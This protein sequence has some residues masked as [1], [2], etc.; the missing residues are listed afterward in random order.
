MKVIIVKQDGLV[1]RI[2]EFKE[3]WHRNSCDSLSLSIVPDDRT[4]RS[5]TAISGDF[6]LLQLFA[7]I[8]LRNRALSRDREDF[9][10]RCQKVFRKN[11]ENNKNENQLKKMDEQLRKFKEDIDAD[12]AVLR[13]YT[14]DSFL[15]RI[16]NETLR[17]DDVVILFHSRYV[18]R[19]LNEQLIKRQ[20][21]SPVR[22]YRGQRMSTVE[23]E[24]LGKSKGKLV[25]MKSFLSTSL[26]RRI[27]EIYADVETH[28]NTEETACVIFII[29]AIPSENN[30]KLRPFAD[31][32][33]SSHFGASESEI[34]FM[35][36]SV[37]QITNVEQDVNR[38][39]VISMTTCDQGDIVLDTL[40]SWIGDRQNINETDGE[41]CHRFGE[42]LLGIGMPYETENFYHHLLKEHNLFPPNDNELARC[43]HMLGKAVLATELAES[44]N[45]WWEK[46]SNRQP[47]R[48]NDCCKNEE[49]KKLLQRL[50]QAKSEFFHYSHETPPTSISKQSDQ[51]SHLVDAL[52]YFDQA[53]L[54]V[55]RASKFD[56]FLAASIHHSAAN[57]YRALDNEQ[58]AYK[59]YEKALSYYEECIGKEHRLIAEIYTDIG[60]MYHEKKQLD[61]VLDY[62]TRGLTVAQKCLPDIHPEMGLFHLGIGLVSFQMGDINK[63]KFHFEAVANMNLKPCPRQNTLLYTYY[64]ALYTFYS[65]KTTIDRTPM[66]QIRSV[67]QRSLLPSGTISYRCPGCHRDVWIYKA[68]SFC[69]GC[70]CR[71]CLKQ[72]LALQKSPLYQ[73]ADYFD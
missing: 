70:P 39:W 15:Y 47:L 21:N 66:T 57:T 31:I 62:Y 26:D 61:K 45:S 51:L 1:K 52:T 38:R 60:R 58:N 71:R 4:D 68:F 72:F 12:D 27:A 17:T 73:Y 56:S 7:Y 18:I 2:E 29:D 30:K 10:T 13:W 22:V 32:T 11:Y 49:S 67:K 41:I 6:L 42:L 24:L 9:C 69:K 37:F 64:E 40:F 35:L 5:A 44:D 48:N 59:N 16:L 54:H 3:R 23:A 36:G 43:Y 55:H 28:S 8:L 46:A 34:L 25:C 19:Q 50:R 63:A 53:L 33:E 20:F 65:H 14:K